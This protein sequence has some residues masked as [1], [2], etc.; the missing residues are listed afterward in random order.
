[1]VVLVRGALC[2]GHVDLLAGAC[3][4]IDASGA[5][6]QLDR[7]L[8]VYSTLRMLLARHGCRH[9]GCMHHGEEWQRRRRR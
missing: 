4:R 9:G 3:Q 8:R 1:M 2:A 6:R 7:S 5:R